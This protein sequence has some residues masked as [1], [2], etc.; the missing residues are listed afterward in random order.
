MEKRKSSLN[1]F[2]T[3]FLAIDVQRRFCN[4]TGWGD[5]L[6]T[7]KSTYVQSISDKRL[8]FVYTRTVGDSDRVPENVKR[9]REIGGF[10]AEAPSDD[11]EAALCQMYLPPQSLI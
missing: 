8:L 4:L 1:P 11:P 5:R 3:A 6:P 9:F 7:L 2:Q 10:P